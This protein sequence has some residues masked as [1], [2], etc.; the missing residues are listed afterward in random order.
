LLSLWREAMNI[1]EVVNLRKH[2][3][4]RRGF[5]RRVVG[6][7]KAVDGVSFHIR[8]GETLALV[9][10]SGCGKTTVSRCILRALSPTSGEIR[11]KVD[12]KQ[13]DLAALSKRELK[14]YRRHM[15]MVFQDPFSSLNPRMGIADIIGEPLLVNG[16][17]S[18]ARGSPNCST[19]CSCRARSAIAS[20]THLAVASASA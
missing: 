10:E 11:F 19:W 8:K 14:R 4:I 6:Q 9:G 12:G 1:L 17:H 15:Q 20:R 5:L 13:V 16:M 18:A 7:V 2:F 3:P